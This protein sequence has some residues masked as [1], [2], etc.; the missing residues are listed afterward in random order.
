MAFHFFVK[1]QLPHSTMHKNSEDIQTKYR[2]EPEVADGALVTDQCKC[3][4]LCNKYR[5]KPGEGD[6]WPDTHRRIPEKTPAGPIIWWF[7]KMGCGHSSC[8]KQHLGGTQSFSCCRFE[9]IFASTL[10]FFFKLVY[11]SLPLPCF[12]PMPV[13]VQMYSC[14]RYV[15]CAI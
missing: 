11:W 14:P 10:N 9:R 15:I 3:V 13:H 12:Q 2:S 6:K 4:A 1:A 7:W 5:C 8:A